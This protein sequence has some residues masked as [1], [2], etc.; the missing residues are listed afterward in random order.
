[1]PYFGGDHTDLLSRNLPV[2]VI[3]VGGK[4]VR[5]A[6]VYDLTLANYGVDRGLGG[7]NHAHQ[8]RRRRALHP[9]L[10][11]E[12]LRRAARRHHHGGARVRRKRRQDP[13]QIHGHPRRRAEPL[14]PQRHDLS[15][16]HQHA[17][18]V[19][20]YRSVGRRLG[21]LRRPGKAA[22]AD[23]L[24]AAGVRPRLASSVAPDERHL[25]L[26]RPHQPVAARETGRVGDPLAHRRARSR[27]LPADRLQRARRAHGLAA[28]R[29]AARNQPA[30]DHQ[31]GRGG[32][33]R[34]GQVRGRAD[35]E[36]RVEICL[37]GSGQPEELPAQFVRLALQSAG[38]IGQGPRVFPQVS[39]RYPERGAGAGSRRA[40]RSQAEGS[41]VA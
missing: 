20:L 14:V 32:R 26:L 39:A 5:I 30:G 13:W 9:G 7:P 21:A 17:D 27:R 22:A 28:V 15:R 11:R 16:H 10:G 40:W 6:T 33:H 29:T 2:K 24:G 4:D 31:G 38:F 37:R 12:A 8:L 35:Q 41:G 23:R 34:S 19:R 3:S 36:R 25:L 1:M 18:D